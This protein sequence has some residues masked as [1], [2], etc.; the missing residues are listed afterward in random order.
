MQS[1]RLT[2]PGRLSVAV[3][4]LLLLGACAGPGGS[5]PSLKPRPGETPRVIEAPGGS[6]PPALLAEEQAGLQADMKRM[7]AALDSV[8]R[9]MA[10]A[11]RALEAALAAARGAPVGAEAWSNA[12]MALSRYDL[13]RS[14]LGDIEAQVTP[15]L[16]KVD[17]LPADDADRQAV[18]SL[19]AAAARANLE[20][21]RRADAAGAALRN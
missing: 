15:L 8:A 3:P 17:S 6:A 5:F 21:Q 16:R 11:S 12:Q 10:E 2:A 20:G 14:P 19:G 4:A 1:L 18:E 7:T 9:D 13:A